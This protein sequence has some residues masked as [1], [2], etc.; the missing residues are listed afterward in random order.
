MLG[1]RLVD[2]VGASLGS[3]VGYGKSLGDLEPVAPPF[4]G[5]QGGLHGR[6]PEL[7]AELLGMIVAG[8]WE[9]RRE[10]RVGGHDSLGFDRFDP[11]L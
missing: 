3:A 9:G 11:G 2:R 7:D 1:A 6:F 8:E 4:R 5:G 10:S